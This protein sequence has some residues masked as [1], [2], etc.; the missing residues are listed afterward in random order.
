[1]DYLF[2]PLG[3]EYCIWFY[4]L[5]IVSFVSLLIFIIPAFIY[6]ITKKKDLGYFFSIVIGS[7]NIFI[8][9]FVNRL[10][11]SMCSGTMA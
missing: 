10:L 5:S 6:G 8:A 2:G 1:M 9:Y 7:L 3:K 4:F 11:H